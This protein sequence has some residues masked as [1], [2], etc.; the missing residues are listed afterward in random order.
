MQYILDAALQQ[1]RL[2]NRTLVIPS[3][4]YARSCEFHMYVPFFFCFTPPASSSQRHIASS[5]ACADYALMVNRGDAVGS[6][7]WRALPIE[8]QMAFRIPISI[9]IDLPHLRA[10]HSVVTV[11]EYLRLHG[12]DP[13]V[14]S[15]RG[16]WERESYHAHP[17]VFESNK[18]KTPSLFVIENRWYEPSGSNRVNYIPQAMKDRGNWERYSPLQGQESG[19][20]WPV[21]EPTE[22]SERLTNALGGVPPVLDWD[23]AK[24][25]LGAS[26]LELEI[27]LDTDQAVE[28]VLNANGWEVLHTFFSE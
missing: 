23:A 3:F 11:S 8:K 9:M 25:V 28:D 14:E 5:E 21:V 2:L 17:N 24:S 22:I 18:T 10:R 19:G 4:V 7:A 27:D 1:A 6:D 15:S 12:L 20:Y 26:E 13:E 16:S